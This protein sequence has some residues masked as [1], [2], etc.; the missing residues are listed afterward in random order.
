MRHLA[1]TAFGPKT[2]RP[3]KCVHFLAS[4]GR[5]Q[6]ICMIV[7]LSEMLILLRL[8]SFSGLNHVEWFFT[9]EEQKKAEP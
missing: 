3:L 9:N 2:Q 1:K 7:L 4:H 5:T 6:S 8:Y